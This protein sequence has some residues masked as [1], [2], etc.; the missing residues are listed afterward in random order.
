MLLAL[1]LAAG[2]ALLGGALALASRKRPALLEVTRTFAFAAAGGVVALHLFPELLRELGA[3]GLLWAALG[4]AVPGLL[5]A[6]AKALGPRLSGRGLS[7]AR[8]AAETGFVAL[9]VHSLLEGLALR[10]AAAG[11]GSHADLQLALVAHHAP[12]TAAVAL[13]LL[14]LYGARATLWRILAIAAAGGLGALLGGAGLGSLETS[15]VLG[16][17]GGLMAGALLHVVADE[18]HPQT[19][20]PLTL[21][22]AD[23]AAAAAGLS[24]A[25]LA[26]TA[27]EPGPLR[28]SVALAGIFHQTGGLLLVAAPALLAGD[29]LSVALARLA[30]RRLAGLFDLPGASLATLLV[31]LRMLGPLPT[32][33]RLLLAL[34]AAAGGA[35]LASLWPSPEASSPDSRRAGPVTTPAPFLGALLAHLAECAPRRLAVLLFGGA[36]LGVLAGGAGFPLPPAPPG[37]FT[38]LLVLGACSVLSAAAAAALSPLVFALAPAVPALVAMV[39]LPALLRPLGARA[40]A[41][42]PLAGLRAGPLGRQLGYGFFAATGTLAVSLLLR[43]GPAAQLA[44]QALAAALATTAPLASSLWDQAARAPLSALCLAV[45]AAPLLVTVWRAGPRGWL[46]PLRHGGREEV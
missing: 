30:P 21:R 31:T 38:L 39:L 36:T 10:A 18:I 23:L 13:P 3:R 33:A 20:G 41:S 35:L 16:A 45:L 15:G 27:Q 26:A 34:G 12:L 29:L 32:A 8:V 44:P 24:V 22:L 43:A 17:A 40:P 11:P 2:S 25:A 5:E 28:T 14:E 1:L 46:V 4:F 7:G 6:G 42:S 9:A 37:P 19:P